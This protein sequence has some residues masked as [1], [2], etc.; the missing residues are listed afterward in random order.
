MNWT[1]N[2][3]NHQI[4]ELIQEGRGFPNMLS[5]FL[6]LDLNRHGGSFLLQVQA[7]C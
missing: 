5:R 2:K 3:G 6:A 1:G 4:I 7:F